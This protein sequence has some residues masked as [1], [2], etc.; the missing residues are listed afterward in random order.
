MS[1][2]ST[3][4]KRLAVWKHTESCLSTV[5]N[6]RDQQGTISVALFVSLLLTCCY[7][8]H[9]QNRWMARRWGRRDPVRWQ[10]CRWR[11]RRWCKLLQVVFM[12]VMPKCYWQ[13]C[14]LVP[15]WD[16]SLN[17]KHFFW[18]FICLIEDW[19]NQMDV[20]D[21]RFSKMKNLRCYDKKS[22][23]FP[24]FSVSGLKSHCRRGESGFFQRRSDRVI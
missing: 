16:I 7:S 6:H 21:Y 12:V 4:Q 9:S 5:R 14:W 11:G 24:L 2:S 19:N 20:S 13:L 15:V 3:T 10:R 17:L 1:S 22:R 8:P 23:C 18:G